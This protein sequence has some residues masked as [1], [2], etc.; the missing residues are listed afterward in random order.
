MKVLEKYFMK[1]GHKY[2]MKVVAAEAIRYKWRDKE[3]YI[4]FAAVVN[5]FMLL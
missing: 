5:A 2:F 1:F 4:S 3:S